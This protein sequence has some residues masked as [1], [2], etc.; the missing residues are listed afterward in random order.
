MIREFLNGLCAWKDFMAI[1]ISL[2]ALVVTVCVPI[3]IMKYQRYLN[4]MAIYMG[5]D[6]AHALQCIIDFFHDDCACDVGKISVT[7]KN[8]FKNDFNP[9]N[10]IDA[11]NILHYQRRL[12]NDYFFELEMCRESSWLLR[13]KIEK[14]WT[15]S[16]AWVVK[17]LIYMNSAVD[18]DPE[19]YKDISC[20]KSER[21]PQTKGL[22][23]YLEKFYDDLR[24]GKRWLT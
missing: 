12:L 19:M 4:L 1:F 6:V 23:T 7:Y 18:S 15:S 8:R 14:S 9:K 22:N 11:S 16:E 13:R 20:I 5:I 3:Q 17:I 2:V 10:R 24:N 21:V